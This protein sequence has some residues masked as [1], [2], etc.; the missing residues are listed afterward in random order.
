MEYN[1]KIC[2]KKYSTPSSLSN[3]KKIYHIN[4]EEDINNR[5]KNEDDKL[6]HCKYCEKKYKNHR[7]RWDHEKKC[8]IKV[9]EKDDV[10][11]QLI[12]DKLKDEIIE[13]QKKLIKTDNKV[14]T[15]TF[16]AINKILKERS[17]IKNSQNNNTNSLNTINSHNINNQIIYNIGYEEIPKIL[18]Q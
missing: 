8:I 3:H 13:L 11:K 16:K 12:I 5:K 17:Y 15:R 10:Q 1:C 14:S 9:N 2:N 4:E 6:Y 7:S 18:T